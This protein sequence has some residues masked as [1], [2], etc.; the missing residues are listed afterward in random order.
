MVRILRTGRS[1]GGLGRA[2]RS[3][4]QAAGALSWVIC[5]QRLSLWRWFPLTVAHRHLRL[6]CPSIRARRDTR[7][8]AARVRRFTPLQP[9]EDQSP[10]WGIR[11]HACTWRGRDRT[12]A[13]ATVGGE[14]PSCPL[15]V[16]QRVPHSTVVHVSASPP[17]IPDGRISRVRWAAAAYPRRTFPDSPRVKRSRVYA[18]W[19]PGDTSSS[20]SLA[21]VTTPWLWVQ[22]GLPVCRPPLTESPFA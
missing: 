11:G 12:A 17:L 22:M 7:R 15:S 6:R 2:D 4:V 21:G 18:P 19:M 5:L 8:E 3:V 14:F 9:L 20:T 13:R 10:G 1:T 16:V